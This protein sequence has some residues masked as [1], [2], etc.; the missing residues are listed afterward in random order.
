MECISLSGKSLMFLYW[1]PLMTCTTAGCLL[2]PQLY[3]TTGVLWWLGKKCQFIYTY[4]FL[5]FF[6]EYKAEILNTKCFSELR[7]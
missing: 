3:C 7:S 4:I 1:H 6:L 2:L 5:F